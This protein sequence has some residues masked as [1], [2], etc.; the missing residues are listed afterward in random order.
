MLEYR[1]ILSYEIGY[2]YELG[3]QSFTCILG[4][5]VVLKCKLGM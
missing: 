4:G 1:C 5:E 3:A 2:E